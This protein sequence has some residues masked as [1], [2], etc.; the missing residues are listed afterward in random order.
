[1]FVCTIYFRYKLNYCVKEIHKQDDM[2]RLYVH[3]E[4]KDLQKT[5]KEIERLVKFF[6]VNL[7]SST[8]LSLIHI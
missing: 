5:Q 7:Y 8:Y 3:N 6:N 4:S 1:M 2:R